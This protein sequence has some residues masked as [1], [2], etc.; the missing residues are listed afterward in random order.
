MLPWMI[1]STSAN[2]EEIMADKSEQRESRDSQLYV[3]GDINIVRDAGNVGVINQGRG[4][5][6]IVTKYG[7]DETE[8]TRRFMEIYRQIDE[9]PV[10]PN[11]D[12]EEIARTVKDI[13]GEV[14]EKEP[15]TVKIKRWLGMLRD[16]SPKIRDAVLVILADAQ[17]GLS[18][19]VCNL[20]QSLMI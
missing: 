16:A 3:G 2:R 14:A 11:V 4:S 8:I 13:E 10:D 9:S 17:M 6:K 18:D 19:S 20:A 15:N 7:S 12:K 5:V 1:V